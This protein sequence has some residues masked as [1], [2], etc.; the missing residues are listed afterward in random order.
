MIR[1]I[2]VQPQVWLNYMEVD[3]ETKEEAYS[4][5][6]AGEGKEVNRDWSHDMDRNLWDIEEAGP[7][8]EEEVIE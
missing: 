3:A 8:T 2:V 6:A 4:K 1:W 7:V 5:V